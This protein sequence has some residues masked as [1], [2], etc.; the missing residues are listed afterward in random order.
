MIETV[1]VFVYKEKC[2][3]GSMATYYYMPSYKGKEED[4]NYFCEQCVPRGCSCTSY[5][6][7]DESPRGV[8]GKDWKW[9]ERPATKNSEAISKKDGLWTELDEQGR[10]YVCCEF[11]WDKNGFNKSN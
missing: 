2:K 11:M 6:K 1:K 4:E 5:Q 9:I 8:E 10:E 3:C 7:D